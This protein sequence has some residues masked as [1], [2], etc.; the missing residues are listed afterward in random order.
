VPPARAAPGALGGTVGRESA[1]ASQRVERALSA[2]VFAAAIAIGLPAAL[3][4]RPVFERVELYA[5]GYL[6]PLVAIYLTWLERDALRT[7]VEDLRPPRLGPAFAL[8]AA[9]FEL[10]MVAGDVRFAAVVGIS[11][12]LATA[13]YGVGGMPLLRP[14][15]LPLLFLALMAPLPGFV[16]DDLLAGLKRIV[17][18]LA[19][20]IL[21]RTGQP[22]FQEGNRIEIPGHTLFVAD[23]CS[24]LTSIVTL[25]PVACVVAYFL[26]RG[27]WRRGVVV[28][29]VIPLAM[30][31]NVVRVVV[32]VR[33]VASIGPAAAQGL[34]HESFGLATYAVGT[35]LLVAV[36]RG[37]R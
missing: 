13:A 7:A 28:L 10:T 31:A 15:R 17:T 33:L 19:V 18:T 20:E 26:S 36:A 5:H 2:A 14:L 30:L 3:G 25:L 12:L 1:Q 6:M 21:Y 24:G 29:S 22:I 8:G 11:L 32:T 9:A 4:L 27:L 23:A 35:V 34:L 37:L 16:V